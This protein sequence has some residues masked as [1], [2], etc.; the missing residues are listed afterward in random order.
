MNSRSDVSLSKLFF[1]AVL[2]F[3]AV[4]RFKDL[5]TGLPLHSLF[6]ETDMLNILLHMMKTGDLNPHQFDLPGLAYYFLLPFLY[7]FYQIGHWLHYFPE[8]DNVP[9]FSFIFIGRL[10]CATFGTLSVYL[11]YRVGRKFSEWTGL[12][13]MAILAAM[14]QHIEYSHMLRPEIPAIFFMLIALEIAFSILESP[15]MVLYWLFGVAIGITISLKYTV[16]LPLL[17]LLIVTHWFKRDEAKLSWLFRSLLLIAIVFFLSNPFVAADPEVFHHWREKAGTLYTTEDYY[18]KSTVAYY[19]EF[20]TRYD[21]NI[22]LMLFAA[23]GMVLSISSSF[24]KA[25]VLGLYPWIVFLWLCSFPTRR[26]HGLLPMHPF[27][28]IWAAILLAEVKRVAQEFSKKTSVKFLYLA[29]I[30]TSL[31]WP[32]Y[33]SGV[34]AYLFSK[35]D[36]R[37]KAEL[38]MV[39][40]LPRESKIALLQY[41]QLELDPTYFDIQSFAPHDYVLNNKDF[42]WFQQHGFQYV[43]VSSG[44]YMR[45][46]IEGRSAQK[47]KDYFRTLFQDGETR[48]TLVLDLVPH[49]ILIPDYRIKIYATQ[50]SPQPAGFTPA[51]D[52]DT[53][54]QTYSL[55]HSGVILSLEPGYYS[56]KFPQQPGASSVTVNNLKLNEA[57]LKWN[58]AGAISGFP[59]SIL[60]VRMNSE[61][62]L[63][64][65]FPEIISPNQLVQFLWTPDRDG[66][67]LD[68][69]S[70]GVRTTATDFLPNPV[71]SLKPYLSFPKNAPFRLRCTL[72]NRGDENVA[73]YIEGYLSQIG[74]AEPWKNYDGTSS[75]HEFF[76]EPTQRITIEIPMSTEDL[77]GDY[78][79]SYWIFT[80]QDLP[81][82]P[83]NGGLFNKQIRVE[84]SKLDLHPIYGVSIP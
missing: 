48:G 4:V 10:I 11:C 83:Q 82:S 45:Y 59:F 24:Q 19:I 29:L 16:G 78:Q 46:F 21:Y 32:F 37:S 13:A 18:G 77:T 38:W 66:L 15:R 84:D 34:Q 14:P 81:F 72:R 28:A 42:R 71:A 73:G 54:E 7:L 26:P 57:I 75:A 22:P 44:Q 12:L 43:V 47:Y 55:Y 2:I 23:F 53:E 20:L 51:I 8:M 64:A 17:P 40:R 41:N 60:P 58:G 67:E 63:F 6:G 56:L 27:L 39:N 31:A 52:P 80:R 49:P 79:L 25:C 36:N 50:P 70:P 30:V 61:F 65:I 5:S 76:L 1:W 68:R 62:R 35:I 33:R 69:I 9:S 3:A 74:D